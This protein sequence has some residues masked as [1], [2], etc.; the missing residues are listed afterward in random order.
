[1]IVNKYDLVL[2][3]EEIPKDSVVLG[4]TNTVLI[5]RNCI[6]M[7]KDNILKDGLLRIEYRKYVY[8][9]K[10]GYLEVG[11]DEYV[12]LKSMS[13]VWMGLIYMLIL[14]MIIFDIVMFCC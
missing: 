7:N 5:E 9:V 2:F 1:M 4:E 10:V 6:L 12:V 14:L 8:G 11:Y 3:V 13:K